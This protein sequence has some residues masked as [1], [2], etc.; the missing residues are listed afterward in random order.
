MSDP[1]ILVH[2]S[3]PDSA[4]DDA[5]YRNQ[6]QAYLAFVPGKRI[7]I[8]NPRNPANP[9]L[10]ELDV[11]PNSIPRPSTR[12]RN[13]SHKL[14]EPPPKR[15]RT[16]STPSKAK[17]FREAQPKQI[18]WQDR[19][20]PRQ[21]TLNQRAETDS[22]FSCLRGPKEVLQR[23]SQSEGFE[24]PSAIVPNSQPEA[25]EVEVH[26][27]TKPEILEKSKTEGKWRDDAGVQVE[28]GL[29]SKHKTRHESGTGSSRET[30]MS[31]TVSMPRWS[32]NA[33]SHT[34][35]LIPQNVHCQHAR[36]DD[37][38]NK[39]LPQS[40]ISQLHSKRQESTSEPQHKNQIRDE[41]KKQKKERFNA[42]LTEL[43]HQNF[44]ASVH[45]PPPET[46]CQHFKTHVTR[47]LASVAQLM[48]M[49]ERY[50]P[51]MI[52]RPLRPLERG[53]W[54]IDLYISEATEELIT[55]VWMFL[56]D[57]I[58]PGDVGWGVWA[59]LQERSPTHQ[60]ARQQPGK[61]KTVHRV[62][63]IYCW[64]EVVGHIWMVLWLASERKVRGL[65]AR[66]VDGGGKTVVQMR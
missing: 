64:G 60:A 35:K 55:K 21:Y 46:S 20:I 24:P 32:T 16:D 12:P 26:T 8:L 58:K 33:C 42:L 57:L 50:N 34:E 22:T 19:R 38:V 25:L 39:P 5:R 17:P 11:I 43:R 7:P 36:K 66:W 10:K 27:I 40:N 37:H 30:E 47:A 65:E 51:R 45:P 6:A 56:W 61:D 15:S 4:K 1:E 44:C 52:A 59:E 2:I 54:S 31:T 23:R 9:S 53:H 29:L 62:L 41:K 49:E 3:G 63:N 13:A 28:V 14:T 48:K 18:I